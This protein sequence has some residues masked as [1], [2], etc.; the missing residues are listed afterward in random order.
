MDARGELRVRSSLNTSV[1]A[2]NSM[3]IRTNTKLRLCQEGGSL[4]KEMSASH[5]QQGYIP[6][7][8]K[9]ARAHALTKHVF[10]QIH[11]HQEGRSLQPH[12]AAWFLTK[13]LRFF[14]VFFFLI[15]GPV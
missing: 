12:K 6:T 7:L 5:T 8:K 3:A 11:S 10:L 9:R 4:Q 13:L 15:Q 14:L 1:D 2:K